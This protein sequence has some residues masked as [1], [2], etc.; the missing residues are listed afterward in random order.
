[1]HIPD[2]FLSSGTW[3]SSWVI[4][5]AGIGYCIKKVTKILKDRMVPLMG[6]LAAFVFAAQ[7]VNFPI[8]GGTSGHLLG[9]VL[10]G[11]LLGPYSAAIIISVVLIVQCL[12]FQDGG[13]TTLGA[14]ILNMA[15]LGV[16]A[17]YAS[18]RIIRLLIINTKKGILIGTAIGA[19]LSVVISAAA[20]ATELS[21]SGTTPFAVT[22]PIMTGIHMLIG[23]GEA[24]I[25]CAILSFIL[26]IRPD[27][28]Y[29][30]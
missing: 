6:V 12:I 1:M 16:F 17:G 22:F 15:I 26:K 27:L 19:W 7:M 25:T 29:E 2:G 4:S 28:V 5:G 21:I 11:V 14:N 9:G 13:L 23:I 3:I 8:A 18:Y 30:P 24:F 10:S 20:C